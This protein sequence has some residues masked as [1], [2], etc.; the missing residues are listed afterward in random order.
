M[1]LLIPTMWTLEIAS[2][3]VRR[4]CL[5]ILGDSTHCNIRIRAV[6][7]HYI[8]QL[9]ANFLLHIDLEWDPKV[10]WASMIKLIQQLK[11]NCPVFGVLVVGETGTGKSTLINN[12]MGKKVVQEGETLESQTA[13]ITKHELD[14]EGVPVALYDTP[15]LGDSR[16]DRDGEYLQK[17]EEIL[18]SGAI[19]LVIYCLKLSET[20]MRASLIR[21]FQEYDKIG[22]NWEW[23]IVTLTFAD[24]VPV[25]SS[26]RKKPGF[27]EVQF[28]NNRLAE[29]QA[30]I[31][32]TLVERVG[33]VPEVASEIPCNPSTSDPNER[34]VNGDRWFVPFWLEV[35][36]LLTPGAAMQFLEMRKNN[37]DDLQL[38]PKEEKRFLKIMRTKIGDGARIGATAGA[39]VGGLAAGVL[40]ELVGARIGTGIGTVIGGGVGLFK[41]L[42]SRGK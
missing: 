4:I 28:F 29:M 1:N 42:F 8:N 32:K 21:T 33:V 17:V 12:L 20:R 19:H 24:A 35:L 39:A 38:N 36:E 25:P 16:S 31:T 14:V 30:C 40:G 13:T 23:T 10:F 18:K 37:I 9:I 34:L 7:S 41:S 6:V 26:E 22:V 3:L 5:Y 15:G 27:D 2:L 11:G